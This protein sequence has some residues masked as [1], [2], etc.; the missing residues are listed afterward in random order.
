MSYTQAI[1]LSLIPAYNL[2]LLPFLLV[3]ERVLL[4]PRFPR[5]HPRIIKLA[6]RSLV[7]TLMGVVGALLPFFNCFTALAGAIGYV[8]GAHHLS[9]TIT[10]H[11]GL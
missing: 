8:R 11:S 4:Q 10:S 1:V 6:W 7:V 2:Y 5:M 9:T 3:M